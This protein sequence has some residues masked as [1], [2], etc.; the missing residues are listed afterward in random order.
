MKPTPEAMAT[1]EAK[2]NLNGWVYAIGA[3]YDQNGAVPPEAIQSA[4][5]SMLL[6]RLSMTSPPIRITSPI[7]QKREAGNSGNVVRNI[8]SKWTHISRAAY[9]RRSVTYRAALVAGVDCR[10]FRPLQEAAPTYKFGCR[11]RLPGHR[12]EGELNMGI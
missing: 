8:S 10:Y 12:V 5:T 3:R 9:I 2:R 1:A 7:I 4:C 6:A 11:Y